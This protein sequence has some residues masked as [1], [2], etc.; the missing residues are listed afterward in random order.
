MSTDIYSPVF[1]DGESLPGEPIP[2]RL[3]DWLT[4]FHPIG[5]KLWNTPSGNREHIIALIDFAL[6]HANDRYDHRTNCETEIARNYVW[7]YFTHWQKRGVPIQVEGFCVELEALIDERDAITE[8][9]QRLNALWR[10]GKKI[11][12]MKNKIALNIRRALYRCGMPRT[13]DEILMELESML[14]DGV[15]D[16]SFQLPERD[17]LRRQLKRMMGANRPTITQ[18]SEGQYYLT[19][20]QEICVD[21]MRTSVLHY[22]SLR[23]QDYVVILDTAYFDGNLL[24]RGKATELKRLGEEEFLK[25]NRQYRRIIWNGIIPALT[26]KPDG[27]AAQTIKRAGLW[28]SAR[29]VP[30]G[31]V[32]ETITRTNHVNYSFHS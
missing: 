29:P 30:F 9:Q 6:I 18:N 23:S 7:H 4:R 16:D 10:T 17:S 21:E 20:R 14:L 8:E 25:K 32:L 11:S 31:K 3:H 13:V 15:L 24:P 5:K 26:W 19:W 2:P 22:R 28:D 27:D 12:E 1:C